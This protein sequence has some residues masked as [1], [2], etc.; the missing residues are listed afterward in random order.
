[1]L[2]NFTSRSVIH[3]E[4]LFVTGAM[5]RFIFQMWIYPVVPAPVVEN[6]IFSP[7]CC[8]CSFVQDQFVWV[9]Y[10]GLFLGSLVCFHLSVFLAIPHSL[11]YCSFIVSVAV[12]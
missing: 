5:S 1:M 7:F 10:V 4:L 8:H 9:V 12:E 11:D 6:I 2:P 3:F